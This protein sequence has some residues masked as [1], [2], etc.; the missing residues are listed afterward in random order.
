MFA[1]RSASATSIS[2]ATN[3]SVDWS[4]IARRVG[5]RFAL[6]PAMVAISIPFFVGGYVATEYVGGAVG[7]WYVY[8]LV[9]LV[10]HLVLWLVFGLAAVTLLRGHRDQPKPLWMTLGVYLIAGEVRLAALVAGIE[11]L[12]LENP[13]PLWVRI[14]NTAVLFPLAYG[15][16]SYSL[17]SFRLYLTSRRDLIHSIVQAEIELDQQKGAVNSLRE[18]F[19]GGFDQ[20]IDDANQKTLA[21]LDGLEDEIARGID[22]RPELKRLLDEADRRW[23]GI[24]HE[25][26]EAAK[27]NVPRPTAREF[28]DVVARSKPLSYLSVVLG[29]VFMF[30]L[31]L[32]RQ[33]PLL[34]GAQWT[35]VWIVATGVLVYLTNTLA[36][37]FLRVATGLFMGLYITLVFSGLWTAWIPGIALDAR[38]AAFAIHL[39]VVAT[40]LLVGYGPAA[41]NNQENALGALRRHLDEASISRLKVESEL[42]VLA[43][44]VASRL[45]AENRGDFMARVLNLQRSLDSGDVEKAV[46]DLRGVRESLSSGSSGDSEPDDDDLLRFLANWRGLI[47]IDSN[48]HVANVPDALHPSINTIVMD[49]VNDA[50]RHGE[51]DWVE[52]DL[53]DSGEK[54]VLSIRNN[55]TPPNGGIGGGV[56]GK[57][58][59][60]LATAGWSRE[61]DVLGFTRLRVEFSK[62]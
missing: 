6:S 56:G 32:G 26:L 19:L 9:G 55:G 31:A 29:G 15:F 50:V 35:V 59:D 46:A 52:I 43:Q 27:I 48:L 11:F 40:S 12:G 36:S 18:S 51:A 37:K 21:A 22:A 41:S 53:D 58:L 57:T 4:E 10:A 24:S 5:G 38:F 42:V 3:V 49:A 8:A 2:L 23:R 62:S 1:W 17:E 54:V 13:V 60:R 47:E 16:S 61:V 14:L 20:R 44:K 7:E 25:T 28:L 45:H 34:Q 30:S 33:L 39:T